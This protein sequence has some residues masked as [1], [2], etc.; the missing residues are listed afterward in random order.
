G[1]ANLVNA[2]VLAQE[3]ARTVVEC[4][5]GTIACER[6]DFAVGAE[7]TLCL[8]PEFIHVEPGEAS[9]ENT[10]NGR[11]ESRVFVGEAYE[12]EI[13]VGNERLLARLD[14]DARLDVGDAVSFRLDS[15]HC[16]LVSA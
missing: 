6:R 1:R 8:R 5:L 10:V 4:G 3:P 13:R 15:A 14:P 12:V 7:V 9:G 16:L 11:I 2:R